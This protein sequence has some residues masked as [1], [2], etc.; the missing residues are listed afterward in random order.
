MKKSLSIIA[1]ST[2]MLGLAAAPALASNHASSGGYNEPAGEAA[3]A[4]PGMETP[5]AMTTV[6]DLALSSPDHQTLVSAVVQAGLVETLSGPGPFTI[7]APVDAAFAA[8]DDA[9]VA[10]L[11]SPEGQPM[12]TQI[13]TTHV[14]QGNLA[15][16]DVVAAL[17]NGPIQ[18]PT[19]SGS[20]LTVSLNDGMVQLTDPQGN[21]A[22][23]TAVDL[24]ADNGVVHVID[25]VLLP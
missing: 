12:L 22:T 24:M 14:V 5:M 18:V 9:T 20:Q 8:F 7:F 1:L 2:S 15:S 16:A 17:E 10:E 19:A 4:A 21:T 3:P 23:V 6:V 11:F 25:T 13:L